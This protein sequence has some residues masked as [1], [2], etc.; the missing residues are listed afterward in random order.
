MC[1]EYISIYLLKNKPVQLVLQI[2]KA[3]NYYTSFTGLRMKIDLQIRRSFKNSG[4]RQ[5]YML[6]EEGRRVV[7]SSA[8][9][10]TEQVI[11]KINDRVV[12]TIS[13]SIGVQESSML[14]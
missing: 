14:T 7:R 5:P 6:N 3:L 2:L 1:R 12:R 8:A 13:K 4:Q 9:R 11:R 10:R